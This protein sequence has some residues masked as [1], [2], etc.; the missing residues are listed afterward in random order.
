MF[1]RLVA[2]RQALT[3]VPSLPQRSSSASY[4]AP[5]LFRLARRCASPAACRSCAGAIF[6]DTKE[7]SK[8]L[9]RAPPAVLFGLLTY[10]CFLDISASLRQSL[11]DVSLGPA[12]VS[13]FPRVPLATG[14]RRALLQAHTYAGWPMSQALRNLSMARRLSSLWASMR[15]TPLTQN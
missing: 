13:H 2:C 6:D 4:R 7:T 14:N 12:T 8:P 10:R 5:S 3:L 11:Q 1:P 15:V 9:A